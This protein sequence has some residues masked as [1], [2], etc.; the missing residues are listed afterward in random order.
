MLCMLRSCRKGGRY[1]V[2]AC[3][4]TVSGLVPEAST[5]TVLSWTGMLAR[6]N[7]G[8]G[9]AGEGWA[10]RWGG[11]G[12]GEGRG[13]QDVKG[14]GRGERDVKDGSGGGEGA[15]APAGLVH[16][17]PQLSDG[18]LFATQAALQGPGSRLSCLHLD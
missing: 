13:E 5:N 1:Q 2:W 17:L 14:E 18:I 7:G 15:N 6:V 12:K 16:A 10:G 8:G 4:T 3:S 9:K 11:G